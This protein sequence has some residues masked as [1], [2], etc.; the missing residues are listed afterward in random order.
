MKTVGPL[1]PIV[2]SVFS[3]QRGDRSHELLISTPVSVGGTKPD[4]KQMFIRADQIVRIVEVDAEYSAYILNDGLVVPVEGSITK[5]RKMA[6]APPGENGYTDL[7]LVTDKAA[8]FAPDIILLN[9][10]VAVRK[11]P[12]PDI[13]NDFTIGLWVHDEKGNR[14][15]FVELK[16]S[17]IN[18]IYVM[19][20]TSGFRSCIFTDAPSA[21]SFSNEH[22]FY[23]KRGFLCAQIK[24]T[25]LVDLINNAQESRQTYLDLTRE[26]QGDLPQSKVARV[27]ANAG[28]KGKPKPP[29]KG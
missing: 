24:P 17:E 29:V 8:R 1:K 20:G 18:D 22:S 7:T 21:W 6:Y 12:K 15:K 14:H 11:A 3:D 23:G 28:Q 10:R 26:T 2:K 25:V 27:Q 16:K 19:P 4:V 13:E 9:G 5:A